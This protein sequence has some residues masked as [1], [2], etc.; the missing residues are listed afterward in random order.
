MSKTRKCTL[1]RRAA[2]TVLTSPSGRMDRV[3][4][5]TRINI[6]EFLMRKFKCTKLCTKK[7]ES[8]IHRSRSFPN[9]SWST[10]TLLGLAVS[11]PTSSFSNS[12]AKT[13]A[14]RNSK[15][16]RKLIRLNSP[17]EQLLNLFLHQLP[18]IPMR[19]KRPL[20]R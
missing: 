19:E 4:G 17:R 16:R 2:L 3:L 9:Q 6:R 7:F 20:A 18:K 10:T 13:S 11:K 14:A 8:F 15:L 1:A 12:E 5:N